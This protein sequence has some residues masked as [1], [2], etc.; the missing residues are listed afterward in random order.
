[1]NRSSKRAMT[2]LMLVM[3][4]I[5]SQASFALGEELQGEP[6]YVPF[7]TLDDVYG[8][9][10][11]MVNIGKVLMK[12]LAAA[13]GQDPELAE[14]IKGMQ[15][16]QINVYDTQGRREPAL[17]QLNEISDR[18]AAVQWQPFMHDEVVQGLVVMVVDA[19]EA[20][21]INVVGTIDPNKLGKLMNQ[22]N[23]DVDSVAESISDS[24]T[25]E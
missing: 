4:L 13:S 12:F 1:M 2:W 5:V 11:V 6:G 10:K 20:V 19:E 18:L 25:S 17:K 24:G 7:S 22:L 23:V 16:I 3:A 15:G 21:F 9:P 14:M 8:Q